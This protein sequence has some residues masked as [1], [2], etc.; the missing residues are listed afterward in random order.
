MPF[1]D[2]RD[3]PG[4]KRDDYRPVRSPS[5][6]GY[7]SRDEYRNRDR[8]PRSFARYDGRPRSPSYSSSYR[9]PSPRATDDESALPI[10]RRAPRDV[11]DVQILVL[12]EVAQQFVAYV[13]QGF[14]QKAL[15]A[16]TIW[17]NP[18]ITLA[19]VIKRQIIEGVQAVV[20]LTRST[21]F[22]SKIPL[23]VFDRAAGTS[24]VNFNEYVELDIPVAADI[25]IQARQKERMTMQTPISVPTPTASYPPNQ[26][27][28]GQPPYT[29][30]LQPPIQPQYHQ[31]PSQTYP[32]PPQAQH[33]PQFPPQPGPTYRVPNQGPP[34]PNSGAPNLQELLA[35]LRQPSG[36]QQPPQQSPI[37]PQNSRPTDL[38]GLLS[39]V[40]ARQHNQSHMYNQNYA[41]PLPSQLPMAQY[42]NN[43]PV[44]GY[45]PQQGL[46]GYG[47]GPQQPQQNVQNVMD[48]LARYTGR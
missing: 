8:S 15:R 25:V 1:S 44:Q 33:Q 28:T 31:P 9:A 27:F 34:T 4:R 16:E 46:Q 42:G 26:P 10:P 3:E 47:S 38:A 2:F 19:A 5:P 7:R 37:P 11:P 6:R 22:N 23:Q 43:P 30:P 24:N 18:R 39:N 48:Q 14:R 32:Q 20:K 17:L 12:E 35:N 40:A 13:E 45:S 41:T 29:Y 21:Q 36:V